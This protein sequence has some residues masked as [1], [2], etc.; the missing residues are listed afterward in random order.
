VRLLF[1]TDR[2]HVPD[3]YSGSVQSTHALIRGLLQ[4]GHECRVLASLP[5][6]MRHLAAT[7]VHKLSSQ[8]VILEWE[9]EIVGYAV[10][11]GSCWRFTE[12]VA[13]ESKR[14]QPDVVIL[15]SMRML[16]ALAAEGFAPTCPIIVIMHDME[17]LQEST[18]VPYGADTWFV[19]NSPFTASKLVA[20]FNVA[21][22]VIPPVVYLRD[23]AADRSS[24]RYATMISPH[25]RKGLELVLG[26]AQRLPK[27]PF[28]LVEG[29][30]M[31]AGQVKELSLRIQALPNVQF[32]RSTSDMRE[33]Y[34]ETSVLLVPSELETFGRVV[35]EA[36]CSG[37]PVLASNMGALPW[38]VGEGGMTLDSRTDASCW[39]HE[40]GRL[41]DDVSWYQELSRRAMANTLRADFQPVEVI[42]R[43][44]RLLRECRGL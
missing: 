7:A 12:R 41:R 32:R 3:D 22:T 33:V 37:I 15:D 34:R 36:Q 39:I 43:F 40:L 11:R 24:A 18:A 42:A 1:A 28:L 44:N 31:S 25:P 21:P 14:L 6:N 13:R 27:L 16:R 2:L 23:Y 17:F 5:R 38:V 26:I 4:H 19:A 30:P 20:H 29:W 9:D 35:V 8:R 10:L